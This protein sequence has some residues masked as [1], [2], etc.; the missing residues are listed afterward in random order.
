MGAEPRPMGERNPQQ[1]RRQSMI[2]P[3]WEHPG[4]G[5]WLP[6]FPSIMSGHAQ[7]TTA[8]LFLGRATDVSSSAPT[9]NLYPCIYGAAR[10]T[11]PRVPE[12]LAE[13]P[14][15]VAPQ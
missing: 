3:A 2:H 11:K 13:E 10:G 12:R 1:E 8:P 6:I 14:T 7:A 5:A 15:T 4:L 9:A